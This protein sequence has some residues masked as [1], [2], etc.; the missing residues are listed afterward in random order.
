[1]SIVKNLKYLS[2]RQ[3]LAD[4]SRLIQMIKSSPQFKD[5]KVIAVGGSY[6]GNL[7]A[8]MRL[9][10]PNQV[11]AAW[12]SSAPVLAKKNFQEFFADWAEDLQQNFRGCFDKIA[13]TFSKYDQLLRSADGIKQ[14]KKEEN[15]C[16]DT[17]MSKPL[18]K[19]SFFYEK[20]LSNPCAPT[21]PI[22]DCNDH[23]FFHRAKTIKDFLR[24]WWY[25]TCTEFGY[26]K[27]TTNDKP[28]T[29]NLILDYYVKTCA[30]LFGPE[31]DEKR[32]DKGIADT[33]N[34]YGGLKPKVTRVVFVNGSKD[35][36]R[37]LG[38][39]KNLSKDAPARVI[40]NGLHGQDI[41]REREQD[42]KELFEA[43]KYVKSLII[44]WLALKK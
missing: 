4:L 19:A 6:A 38:I 43:R 32:I 1:M 24:T 18:N 39:M 37:L 23:V 25:Q 13:Q 31:F 12:S 41:L 35:P 2:S 17:D 36:W 21:N 10:Y 26:F 44:R 27:P 22:P 42:S 11:H 34:Q 14:I 3:A 40:P 7:A 5:S 29:K 9:K 8:W 16:E 30:V 15:I 33:N 28:F 20:I